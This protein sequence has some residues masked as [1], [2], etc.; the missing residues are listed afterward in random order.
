MTQYRNS[1]AFGA[2]ITAWIIASGAGHAATFDAIQIFGDSFSDTG[3]RRVFSDGGTAAGYLAEYFGNPAVLPDAPNPGTSSINFAE[4]A[5]RVDVERPD[6]PSSVTS[7]VNNY[8]DLVEQGAA[9]FDPETTLFFLSGGLNDHERT[10]A[11]EVAGAYREQVTDLIDLGARYIQV[12]LLPREVPEFTDS[13]DYLNPAY[14]ELVSDLAATYSDVSIELSN[15][16]PYY[17]D[18]IL[19]PED[20]GFTNVTEPCRGGGYGPVT[21][22]CDTPETYF[23]YWIAHPSD[24]AHR[25]VADRLY[26]DLSAL[27]ELPPAPVPLPASA[28]LLIMA[29]GGFGVTAARRR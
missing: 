20:Y 12:A 19:N 22:L 18:I 23:Y 29:L 27:E 17:D 1:G 26:T 28:V 13:A 3:A 8:I 4:S 7:Q 25:V 21:S 15:W 6:G 9:S 11:S 10:P 24:A 16:G 2:A 5:A 14:R